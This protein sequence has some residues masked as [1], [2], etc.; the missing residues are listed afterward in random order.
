MVVRSLAIVT[1]LVLISFTIFFAVVGMAFLL[2]VEQEPVS[3][4]QCDKIQ[5]IDN[6]LWCM[7]VMQAE[8]DVIYIMRG[9]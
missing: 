8:D 6:Q 7:G 1:T 4:S 3:T 2:N 5:R 9:E